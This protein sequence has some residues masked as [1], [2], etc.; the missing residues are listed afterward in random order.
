M[1][2]SAVNNTFGDDP[3]DEENEKECPTS[4]EITM[5]RSLGKERAK[6]LGADRRHDTRS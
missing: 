4:V 6:T 2:L 5:P 3:N 1:L